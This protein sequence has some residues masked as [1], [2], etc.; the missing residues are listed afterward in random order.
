[1]PYSIVPSVNKKRGPPFTAVKYSAFKANVN[2]SVHSLKLECSSVRKIRNVPTYLT[3]GFSY[4]I[5]LKRTQP[6]STN[7]SANKRVVFV[8]NFNPMPM[9]SGNAPL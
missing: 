1:M 7:G 4:A 6:L 5:R 2:I 8:L 3:R 9:A